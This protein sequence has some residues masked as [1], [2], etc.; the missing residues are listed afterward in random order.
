MVSNNL[1][2]TNEQTRNHT[3]QC[4]SYSNR[5]HSRHK[6]TPPSPRNTCITSTSSSQATRLPTK[7]KNQTTTSPTTSAPNA[8]RTTS[9][10]ERN[11][12]SRKQQQYS[13]HKNE[14][15]K[16]RTCS[17][18]QNMKQIHTEIVNQHNQNTP[19]NKILQT[20][21]PDIDKS[22]NT[23][24]RSTRVLL[25]QLRTGKSPFL[26]TWKH[27]IDPTKYTSPLCPLCGA[28]E[29]NTEHIF[30]CTHIPTTLEVADLWHNPCEVEG[31]LETWRGKLEPHLM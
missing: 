21:A 30:N 24:P 28:N 25:A 6:H 3:E 31:L 11:H 23:L 20:K 17:H 29:H 18:N 27:K 1:S 7:R 14:L 22:E 26:L 19:D 10:N 8:T 4:P 13:R 12:I 16:H 9:H 15:A 5:M 2:N